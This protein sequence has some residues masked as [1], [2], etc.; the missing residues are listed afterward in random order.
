MTISNTILPIPILFL[1]FDI[2]YT[3]FHWMLH[4]QA[5]YPY[6][7]K[8]HHIQKAPS[9]AT[10]DAINVHP[11]EYI[12]GEYNHLWVVYFYTSILAI[13]MHVGAAI[14]F[15]TLGG[16]LAGINHTR[17]DVTIRIPYTSWIV[18]DSKAHDVHHRIPQS[19]YGQ[20]TMFWDY[21]IGSYRPYN[22]K[23]RIPPLEMQLDETTGKTKQY[24]KQQ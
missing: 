13:P 14:L 9:R 24:Q 21:C 1:L 23:D 22:P 16:I 11:I 4:W 8:H 5:L 6:I 2:T 18:Y 3:T 10:T 20:Y 12:V 19:N 15:L 7:H 17:Y